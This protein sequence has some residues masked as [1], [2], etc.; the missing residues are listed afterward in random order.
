MLL[1]NK[2]CKYLGLKCTNQRSVPQLYPNSN[3][4]ALRN[5]RAK[6]VLANNGKSLIEYT[7]LGSILLPRPSG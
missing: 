7:S 4:K 1:P 5:K 2:L 6:N 3:L